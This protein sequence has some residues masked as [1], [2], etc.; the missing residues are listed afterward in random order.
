MRALFKIRQLQLIICTAIMVI[1]A[2]SPRAEA[3]AATGHR[4]AKAHSPK[5]PAKPACGVHV[6]DLATGRQRW[7]R[8]NWSV[9]EWADVNQDEALLATSSDARSVALVRARD[10]KTLWEW[11]RLKQPVFGSHISGDRLYVTT[12]TQLNESLVS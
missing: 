11:R 1:A 4:S 10:G 9:V 3:L 5:Q 6:L 7:F 12:G 8:A 2:L